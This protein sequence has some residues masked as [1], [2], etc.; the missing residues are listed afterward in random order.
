M[1]SWW[2]ARGRS[3]LSR[4]LGIERGDVAPSEPA[5]RPRYFLAREIALVLAVKC[6]AL[7]AIWWTWFAHPESHAVD[8]ARMSGWLYDAAQPS[9]PPEGNASNAQR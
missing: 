8:A 7:S 6:L 3:S 5:E 4:A 1:K 2:Q 9:T